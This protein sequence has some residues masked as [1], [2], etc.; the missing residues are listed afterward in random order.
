VGIYNRNNKEDEM[1]EQLPGNIL[2]TEGFDRFI[3]GKEAPLPDWH[4]NLGG[5]LFSS[6]YVKKGHIIRLKDGEYIVW[7]TSPVKQLAGGR[8]ILVIFPLSI[9]MGDEQYMP[10]GEFLLCVGN[11]IVIEFCAVKYHT[12][13]E[14]DGI[15]FYYEV[16]RKVNK[17][18]VATAGLGYLLL[19]K[20]MGREGKPLKFSI[21]NR[22][23]D[24]TYEERGRF[25]KRWVR[26][27]RLGGGRIDHKV[28]LKSGINV[29]LSKQERK[30]W[31]NRLLLFGDIHAHSGRTEKAYKEGEREFLKDP[32]KCNCGIKDPDEYYRYAR[33]S[34]RLDFFC[35]TDHHRKSDIS[36]EEDWKYRIQMAKK[37]AAKDF[38]TFL[39]YEYIRQDVGHWNA[40]FRSGNPPYPPDENYP[41]EEVI[42]KLKE[43]GN[44][45]FF[46]HQ[47]AT[48]CAGPVNWEKLDPEIAPIMEI[49]S[50]W[51][52]GEYFGN[53]LSCTEVDVNPECFVDTP[54]KK[55]VKLGFIGSTDEHCGAPGDGATF[56]NPLG[57]GLACVWAEKFSR[58]GIFDAL[59]TRNCYATTGA[60]I[61]LKF[62]VNGIP[63]G[64]ESKKSSAD[65]KRKINIEVEAPEKIKEIV[66]IKNCRETAVK[67]FREETSSTWEWTDP[68]KNKKSKVDFYY[69]RVVLQDGETA[70][71]SPVWIK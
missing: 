65:K 64:Q 23:K 59:R 44:T 62:S 30:K 26:V 10:S 35:L 5:T 7:E 18:E 40:Y 19:P 41:I 70:W 22:K 20:E 36:T 45:M 58:E 27:D 11:K 12:L 31:N 2:I 33:K 53:P 8:G 37:W 1:A 4:R 57:A 38:V 14:Q 50:H 66:I 42:K 67:T 13:W 46:P 6:I 54:L 56:F 24:Y 69:P 43:I 68:E 21:R 9:G 60:R 39:G 55:G 28:Y 34:A 47:V 61:V 3:E 52:S 25:S 49:Y 51:G 17:P 71:G 16:K 63:M 32:R 15:K 48:Y 29:I